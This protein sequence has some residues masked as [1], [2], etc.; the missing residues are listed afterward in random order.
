MKLVYLSLGTNLGN[1]QENINN[2]LTLISEQAGSIVR[3]SSDFHSKPWGFESENTFLNIAIAIHT[4]LDPH[5][6]LNTL[7]DIEKQ[8]GRSKKT[9]EGQYED[10]I[11]DI[12]ILHYANL[13]VRTDTLTLPHPHI[14]ARD[15]VRIPLSEIMIEPSS[16]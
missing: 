12:D 13:T 11:I 6:L 2:A 8:L 9:I 7:Q 3:R 1:K 16:I 15:F 10:R 14:Q 4:T 5:T